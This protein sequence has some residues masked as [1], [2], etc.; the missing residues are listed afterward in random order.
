MSDSNPSLVTVIVLVLFGAL[1][2]TSVVIKDTWK[3]MNLSHS[4]QQEALAPQTKD[5]LK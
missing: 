2:T 4:E 3:Q 5:L 1:F